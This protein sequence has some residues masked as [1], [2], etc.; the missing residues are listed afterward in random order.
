[1]I[2]LASLT[3]ADVG[4]EVLYRDGPTREYGRIN[5]W[6]SWFIYV[7]FGSGHTGAPCKPEQLE[8]GS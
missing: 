8:W 5:S 2:D 1:M 7:R 4:R 3:P 6:N